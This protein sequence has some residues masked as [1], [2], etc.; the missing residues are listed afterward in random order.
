MQLRQFVQS[1]SIEDENIRDDSQPSESRWHLKK[2]M[3]SKHNY[4]VRYLRRA[5][6]ML[7]KISVLLPAVCVLTQKDPNMLDG[8]STIVHLF[9]WKFLDIADE[10]ER[11]L[12]HAGYGGV[13]VSPVT[14]NAV[15][16]GRPWWE[17]YQPISYNIETRSGDEDD[18][19]NMTSRCNSVGVRI[20]VDVIFNHMSGNLGTTNGT[21][22]STAHTQNKDY[23]E[24]PYNWQDFHDGC[25]VSNYQDPNNVRN[26]ELLG[27]RDLKQDTEYVRGKIVDFLNKLV[28]LGVAGFRIDAAKHM[29]PSDLNVI[30]NRVK[31]L[32]T[33]FGFAPGTRPYIYQEVIDLG[34]EA[35]SKTEYINMGSVTEF[36]YSAE[37]GRV[38]RGKDKLHW[39]R[40]W[41][42]GWGFLQNSEDALVFVDNHDNQRGGGDILT[43]KDA[44]QYKMAIAFMLA[45][46]YGSPR[47]MSSYFFTKP[48]TGPPA[49][50]DGTIIS[51]G[52]NNDDTCSNG[53]VCEHRWRQIY[54]MVGFR[55]AVKGAGISNWWSNQNQQIA[56]CRQGK[57]FVAFTNG[58]N[59][60][61]DMQTCLPSGTYC[62]VISGKLRGGRC[63]GKSIIVGSNGVGYISLNNNEFDG[64]LAIHINAKL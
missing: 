61:Q 58:G 60:Y 46:P 26:C 23:P 44:K 1:R 5:M 3:N 11:F 16:S 45:H 21:G 31:D 9:E 30:Y 64:V 25:L 57:G 62:D 52:I 50:K 18:F 28:D 6:E 24:V 10:C 13:Q 40:N 59:I 32:N 53:W 42:P 17:R 43:Y 22:G 7:L 55:N 41:G 47:I 8:R 37:I 14:E 29:W 48:E 36:K 19:L 15:I 38:F 49:D 27:L 39:L 12:Q 51:P 63:T 34:G 35:I 54:D 56:F 20:Y 4:F 2:K 33:D